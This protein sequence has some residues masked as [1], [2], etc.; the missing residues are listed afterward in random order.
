MTK[1]DYLQGSMWGLFKGTKWLIGAIRSGIAAG[2][3]VLTDYE[4]EQVGCDHSF[5]PR[6]R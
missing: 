5:H 4:R 1:V 6:R 3:Y 2:L